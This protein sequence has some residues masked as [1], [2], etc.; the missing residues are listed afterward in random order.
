MYSLQKQYTAEAIVVLNSRTNKIAEL[1][2]ALSKPLSGL[3]SDA[4]VIKTEIE[5]LL[6]PALVE[7]V[8]RQQN[9]RSNSEFNPTL[10]E[11]EDS[12]IGRLKEQVRLLIPRREVSSAPGPEKPDAL[13]LT[14]GQVQARLDVLNEGGSYLLKIRFT[15]KNPRL[16]AEVANA[17][18]ET[19][20]REQQNVSWRPPEARPRGSAHEWT[21]FMRRCSR[22]SRS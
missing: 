4:A 6:S 8:V 1:Q 3:Q 19:Y 17:F 10:R 18:A 22:V 12:L 21:S 14:I 15:S 20:L 9:L 2:S 13:A 16:A 11:P 5:T 7:Q